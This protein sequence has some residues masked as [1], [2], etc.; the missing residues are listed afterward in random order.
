MRKRM[1]M[2][3]LLM[4]VCKIV[5][6]QWLTILDFNISAGE[7]KEVSISLDNYE[8][9]VAFQFDLYLPEGI[10]IESYSANRE[11]IPEST[12]L[13]M[14][15]YLASGVKPMDSVARQTCPMISA[16]VRFLL[17]P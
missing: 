15:R 5:S 9:Y 16:V 13:S 17:K 6:A 7:T 14:A 1:I 3:I 11:R 4:A 12:T 10:T 8:E 2:T